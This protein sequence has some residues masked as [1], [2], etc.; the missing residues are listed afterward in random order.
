MQRQK[1]LCQDCHWAAKGPCPRHPGRSFYMGSRWRPGKKNSKMRL[2]DNRVHGSVQPIQPV[3]YP[4]R[5][6]WPST[7]RYGV[8]VFDVPGSPP[9]G[10]ITLGATN[11]S[12]S[13]EDGT[14]NWDRSADPARRAIAEK[15]RKPSRKHQLKLPSKELGWPFPVRWN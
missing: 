13:G 15:S 5:G 4:S 10:L 11:F 9:L 12:R 8:T 7:Y 2:W 14:G 6:A 3:P 1:R